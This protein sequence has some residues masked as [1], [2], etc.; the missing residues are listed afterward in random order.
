MQAGMQLWRLMSSEVMQSFLCLSLSQCEYIVEFSH[1]KYEFPEVDD[2][3]TL[4]SLQQ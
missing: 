1:L 2:Q 3:S 4:Y